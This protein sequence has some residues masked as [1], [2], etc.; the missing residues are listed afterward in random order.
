MD[1]PTE[2]DGTLHP[3]ASPR[4]VEVLTVQLAEA[5]AESARMRQAL[6]DAVHGLSRAA[7]ALKYHHHFT[8]GD[9]GCSGCE[10]E[11]AAWAYHKAATIAL[12][13]GTPSTEKA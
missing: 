8:V 1:W 5:R 7:A 10:D 9:K 13:P 12:A 11:R 3:P 2:D 6:E 4:C